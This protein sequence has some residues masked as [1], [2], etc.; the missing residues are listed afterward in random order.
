MKISLSQNNNL[1]IVLGLTLISV[2][3]IG[4][5]YIN[6][7]NNA[8]IQTTNVW[9]RNFIKEKLQLKYSIKPSTYVFNVFVPTSDNNL[10]YIQNWSESNVQLIDTTGKTFKTFGGKGT[11]PTEFVQIG[12]VNFSDDVLSIADHVQNKICRF[13]TSGN[14]IKTYSPKASFSR[15][16]HLT[17]YKYLLATS[18][19]LTPTTEVF[20]VIDIENED[21]FEIKVQR[22]L[23]SKFADKD[24]LSMET[25][26]F[27]VQ[28]REGKVFRISTR[29]G[30][31]VAFDSSGVHLYSRYT[32]DK[33]PLPEVVKKG[34]GKS[35]II[36]W[37]ENSRTINISASVD[38]KHLYILSNAI[39][40]TIRERKAGENIEP[41][42]DIYSVQD[43]YYKASISLGELDNVTRFPSSITVANGRLYVVYDHGAIQCFDLPKQL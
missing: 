21:K 29:T 43:G 38:N 3:I 9:Q 32:I 4:M 13:D 22:L 7:P 27:F 41:V 12:N 34:S 8:T 16:T 17:G 14:L 19:K 39:T 1:P 23:E 2:V 30:Q 28:S 31:F 5:L 35:V 33:S 20:E 11:G 26:G 6:A 10:I 36:K 25:N 24:I 37:G 15:I 40:P 18:Y 42:I